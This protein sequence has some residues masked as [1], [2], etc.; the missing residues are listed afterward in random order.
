M[1]PNKA[2]AMKAVNKKRRESLV[3]QEPV[4]TPDGRGGY[5][6]KWEDRGAVWAEPRKPSVSTGIVAGAVASDMTRE[7]DILFREDVAKG[8][9]ALWGDRTLSVEHTYSYGRE[10]TILVCREV[11]R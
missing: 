10:T 8:W 4:K 3:L 5:T 2:D 9:R 6:T 1:Q 7:W 11:V